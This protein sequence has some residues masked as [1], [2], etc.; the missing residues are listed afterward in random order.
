MVTGHRASYMG[1]FMRRILVAFLFLQVAASCK[2]GEKVKARWRDN[3]WRDAEIVE[4]RSPGPCATYRL[5][6]YHDMTTCEDATTEYGGH[7]LDATK[8]C[9][10]SKD[11]M[12]CTTR[13]CQNTCPTEKC[14]G[15]NS[16]GV[17]VRE[18]ADSEDV[19]LAFIFIIIGAVAGGLVLCCCL[20]IALSKPPPDWEED[21][22]STFGRSKSRNFTLFSIKRSLS[23]KFTGKSTAKAGAKYQQSSNN[24]TW[25]APSGKNPMS[26]AE[27]AA[28]A[29]SYAENQKAGKDNTDH[30]LD[31]LPPMK[32]KAERHGSSL[33][34]TANPP[35]K[36]QRL[37]GQA[38]PKPSP[39][40]SSG[41]HHHHHK[42]QH[43]KENHVTFLN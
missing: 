6:W 21:A 31:F 42:D 22:D 29:A 20:A 10:V 33:Q 5:S 3:T 32:P 12:K 13:T 1:S 36:G 35:D 25:A 43:K 34:P 24:G 16:G 26:T 37:P 38:S 14:T 40:E 7:A 17:V 18:D 41:N 11:A 39:R 19:D 30:S 2:V 15:T 27:A 9:L 4:V 8:F 28:K 23:R